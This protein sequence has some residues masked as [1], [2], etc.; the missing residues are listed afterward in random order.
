[1]TI[2][3]PSRTSSLPDPPK[4]SGDDGGTGH[5]EELRVDPIGLMERVRAEC[6]DVGEFRLADEG[7]DRDAGEE[8][9]EQ[10]Q[11]REVRQRRGV[12]RHPALAVLRDRGPD[13]PHAADR[14]GECGVHGPAARYGAAR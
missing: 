10:R 12:V 7:K 14:T 4:V 5:L 8:R 9:R 1:M 13:G 11:H 6:G 3:E 2:T